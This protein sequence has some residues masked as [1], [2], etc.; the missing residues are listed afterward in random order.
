[1]SFIL[2]VNAGANVSSSAVIGA[3]KLASIN[4]A[5]FAFVRTLPIASTHLVVIVNSAIS[6][7]ASSGVHP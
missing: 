4:A 1:L 6:S 7:S 2:D 3:V 5:W